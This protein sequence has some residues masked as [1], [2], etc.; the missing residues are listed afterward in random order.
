MLMVFQ[1]ETLIVRLCSMDQFRGNPK[2]AIMINYHIAHHTTNN[3]TETAG[4]LMTHIEV[5]GDP[6]T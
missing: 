3:N 6:R 5:A 2:P 4:G 1:K